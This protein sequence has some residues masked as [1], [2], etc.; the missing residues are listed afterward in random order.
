MSYSC[1]GVEYAVLVGLLHVQLHLLEGGKSIGVLF[2]Y[3]IQIL[4]P[5][6]LALQ[7]QYDDDGVLFLQ[8]V[9]P[10]QNVLL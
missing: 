6:I 10:N 4:G 3:V 8:G 9:M 2:E 1:L 5:G 7:E